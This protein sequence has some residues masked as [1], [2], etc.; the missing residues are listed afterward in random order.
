L[1]PEKRKNTLEV[2][3]KERKSKKINIEEFG[4]DK[5]TLNKARDSV[6]SLSDLG[7]AAGENRN[8]R[9]E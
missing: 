9:F 8:N 3:L 6:R 4:Y 1:P 7:R 2:D 5:N